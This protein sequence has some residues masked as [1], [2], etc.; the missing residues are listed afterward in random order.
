MR[1]SASACG[2][3]RLTPGVLATA[4]AVVSLMIVPV[5]G[6]AQPVPADA[7]TTLRTPWGDPDLQGM[8]PSGTVVM[9]PFER[10]EALG[11][12]AVFTDEEFAAHEQGI[13]ALEERLATRGTQPSLVFSEV[14]RPP[15][16]ASLVVDPEDGRLPPMTDDGA[17]RANEWRTRSAPT[18]PHASVQDFRPYE[19]CIS[20]GVLGSA[21]SQYLRVG[22]VDS[23]N[24][25][26]RHH[27]PRDGA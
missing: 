17:R 18:Y 15:P 25:G 4:A 9:V 3:A 10:A 13:A 24:A 21:F 26:V 2:L 16:Q 11:T 1:W 6:Q 22:H 8:W 12:R 27:Q 19:R 23:P 20:R 5:A 14:G 7:W